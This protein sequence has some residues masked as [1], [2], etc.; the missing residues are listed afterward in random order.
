[1]EHPTRTVAEVVLRRSLIVGMV[2]AAGLAG[3]LFFLR[4][5]VPALL[6]LVWLP[7]QLYDYRALR[8]ARPTVVAI[9]IIASFGMM[10]VTTMAAFV[11]ATVTAGIVVGVTAMVMFAVMIT[12]GA[13]FF[14][15]AAVAE[16][17]GR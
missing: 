17:E 12:G 7:L 4:A 3:Y 15:R 10:L 2:I 16:E 13:I 9:A 14:E 5:W 11:F 6:V 8:S 1:M